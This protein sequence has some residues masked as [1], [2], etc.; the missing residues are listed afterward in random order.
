M[1]IILLCLHPQRPHKSST[2]DA[3]ARLQLH[4]GT[5]HFC[6]HQRALRTT[7]CD[8]NQPRGGVGS[9]QQHAAAA[10]ACATCNIRLRSC[11]QLA[12]YDVDVDVVVVV[13]HTRAERSIA[14]A[15]EAAP[16]AL[17][18]GLGGGR[19]CQG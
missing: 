7:A 1:V 11:D 12:A 6:M 3:M 19:R 5:P 8:P 2:Q 17:P 9:Q 10:C 14:A 18:G 15:S 16:E 4:R 13:A